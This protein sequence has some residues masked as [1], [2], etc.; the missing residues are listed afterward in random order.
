MRAKHSLSKLTAHHVATAFDLSRFS[1]A[2]DLGGTLTPP[3]ESG[4]E[5]YVLFFFC[6]KS[7]APYLLMRL[8]EWVYLYK[9]SEDLNISRVGVG[10]WA[11]IPKC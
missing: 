2:C 11:D 8:A 1:S 3:Q 6:I 7:R 10:A 9:P 4:A 5:G